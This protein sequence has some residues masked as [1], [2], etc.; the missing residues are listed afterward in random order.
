M[1]DRIGRLSEHP[2]E[3]AVIFIVPVKPSQMWPLICQWLRI[4]H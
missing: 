4:C 2:K 3:S 1:A